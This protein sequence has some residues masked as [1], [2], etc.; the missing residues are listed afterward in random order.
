MMPRLPHAPPLW[1][2]LL[3]A[4]LLIL[5]ASCTPESKRLAQIQAVADSGAAD[6][7]RTREA[8]AVL[9]SFAH[10]DSLKLVA[11]EARN[12]T[13]GTR[14]SL[15]LRHVPPPIL[16]AA[17]DTCLPWARR[18][19]ALDTALAASQQVVANIPTLIAAAED[20]LRHTAAAA[21][22]G[23]AG[24]MRAERRFDTVVTVVTKIVPQKAPTLQIVGQADWHVLDGWPRAEV[25]VQYHALYLGGEVQP[26]A[27]A[28]AIRAVVGVR[29]AI[30][31]W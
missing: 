24:L 1:V 6:A 25:D 3:T 12:D 20:R 10:E 14:L 13:L 15:A 2:C 11:A 29:Q 4:T 21:D 23:A 31:L 17:P 18:A 7:A 22:S 26:V 28:I 9:R 16:I 30:R 27:G 19:A 8:M 5:A